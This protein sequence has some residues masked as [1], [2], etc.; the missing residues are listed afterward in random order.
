MT[1]RV[2]GRDIDRLKARAAAEDRTVS[3]QARRLIIA[4]LDELDREEASAK[5]RREEKTPS[6][7]D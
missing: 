2:S 3:A 7:G 1:V 4:G 5:R 6:S